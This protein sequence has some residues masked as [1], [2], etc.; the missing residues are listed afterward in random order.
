M[1]ESFAVNENSSNLTPFDTVKSF[2]TLE[3]GYYTDVRFNDGIH[4]THSYIIK[5]TG[6]VAGDDKSEYTA[7]GTLL[8]FNQYSSPTYAERHDSI[9][10]FVNEA[11]G[12]VKP[13]IVAVNPE[14]KILF[15][16]VDQDGKALKELNLN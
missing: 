9:H 10:H 15:K 8:K 5:V 13:E 3:K 12:S 14:N 7:H 6:R 11:S 4:N 1:P 2:R 16:K